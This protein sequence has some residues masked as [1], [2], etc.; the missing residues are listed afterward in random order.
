MRSVLRALAVA[1]V[2]ALGAHSVRADVPALTMTGYQFR[3]A[4]GAHFSLGYTFT[5]SQPIVITALGTMDFNGTSIAAAGSMPV[6]LYY[7]NATTPNIGTTTDG[8]HFSGD[9]VAGASVVVTKTDPIMAPDGSAYVS[10]DGFR[11]HVLPQPIALYATGYELMAN[12]NGTGYATNWTGLTTVTG[13]TAPIKSTYSM[14]QPTDAIYD[15]N[16]LSGNEGFGQAF[17]GPNFLIAVPEPGALTLL[18]MASLGM[19][20]R[21]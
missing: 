7:S 13:M 9:P 11:Y 15:I 3:P 5:L 20:R 14:T 1:L 12:N 19:I 16:V 8:V 21:R 2:L 18:A 4:N 17:V 10:G 6:A